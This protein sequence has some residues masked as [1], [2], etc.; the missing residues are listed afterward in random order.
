MKNEEQN[1][2]RRLVAAN[3]LQDTA[4]PTNFFDNSIYDEENGSEKCES[5]NISADLNE[6][7]KFLSILCGDS[8]VTFQTFDDV[9][10]RGNKEFARIYQGFSEENV[11]SL[12][13]LNQDGAG[14]FVMV[15]EGNGSGRNTEA[16]VN[17]RALFVDLD[18][19]PLQPVLDTGLTPHITVE[20]S[21]ERYHAYWLV[22]DCPLDKFKGLQQAIAARFNGDKSVNDLPRV[23][24]LPGLMHNKKEPFLTHVLDIN[25]LPKY[26]VEQ[27]V[28][29]LGLSI[30]QNNKIDAASVAKKTAVA[31]KLSSALDCID[32][33]PLTYEEWRNVGFALHHEL[34]E[35]GK[36]IFDAWSQKDVARY[37]SVAMDSFWQNI[38]SDHDN[39]LTAATIFK[40]A[41]E[42]GWSVLPKVMEELNQRYFVSHES[43][44]AS[45]YCEDYDD[46]LDRRVLHRSSFA[47]FRNLYNNKKVTVGKN[48]QG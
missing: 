44:K 33:T 8:L 3:R 41:K 1:E 26:T 28:A 18:G 46:G 7:D 19:S 37:S 17:V 29:G 43:G 11:S 14:I 35:N 13:A 45:I 42:R 20:T 48:A 16:V 9:K 15:N 23:M 36:Q 38:K 22:E 47:D 4:E 34:G 39:P 21:P 24:R 40:L 27:I 6:T 32:P 5:G 25:N 2:R 31:G 10:E 12:I 30:V